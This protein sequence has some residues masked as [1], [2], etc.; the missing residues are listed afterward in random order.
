MVYTKRDIFA[1]VGQS[2]QE[3]FVHL[4]DPSD[5]TAEQ[6]SPAKRQSAKVVETAEP[7]E[8]ASQTT[9]DA[10]DAAVHL[11]EANGIDLATVVGT[12]GAGR[13]RQ[14]AQCR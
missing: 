8:P 13:G 7:T 14:V 5:T 11:A 10:T 3:H 12:G 1:E 6:P 9:V 4:V 2:V